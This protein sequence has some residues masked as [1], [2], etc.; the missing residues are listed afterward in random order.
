MRLLYLILMSILLALFLRV[1]L[2]LAR[3][4]AILTPILGWV[5]GLAFFLVTPLTFLS[6]NGG[7]QAPAF[8]EVDSRHANVSLTAVESLPPFLI[9]WTSLLFSFLTVLV[10]LPKP[11]QRWKRREI[12][13]N[14][15]SLKRIILVTVCLAVV[16]YV[17]TIYMAGGLDQFLLLNWYLRVEDWITTLGQ[18]YVL[19]VWLTQANQAVLTA[20]AVLFTHSQARKG[21]VNWR[22]SIFL[23][24]V[25]LFHTAFH[26]ER[27]FLALYLISLLTSCWLYGRKRVVI[28]LLVA[29]PAL[30]VVFSAWASF[31]GAPTDIAKNLPRYMEA[32]LGNRAM[33]V[34]ID[35]CDGSD[36]VLLFHIIRDFGSK[37]GLLY[38]T[39]YARALTFLVPRSI[40]PERAKGFNIQLA[41]KYE[42]GGTTS[43]AATQLGELYANFGLLSV[44]LLP[45]LT[46]AIMIG[47]NLLVGRI[48]NHVLISAVAFVLLIWSARSTL[49]DNF[50]TFLLAAFLIRILRLERNLCSMGEGLMPSLAAA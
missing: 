33:T 5:L 50:I 48:H 32:D 1:F 43:L 28:T 29:A 26:G 42:P 45:G 16:D 39:S 25:F 4:D 9:I 19:Y 27:I 21:A 31:R 13:L 36:T 14:D 12:I 17:A 22:F 23:I 24:V 2:A 18:R 34:M 35:A 30:A 41:E 7:Y 44:L 47:S 8:Y 11:D 15:S 46:V 37:Y 38:G 20:A 49:E 3:R 6:L 10:F 40:Y